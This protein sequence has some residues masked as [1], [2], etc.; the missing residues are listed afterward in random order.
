MVYT[1]NIRMKY[2]AILLLVLLSPVY[3]LDK[4]EE[5]ANIEVRCYSTNILF[6]E[7]LKI[8]KEVPI[9]LGKI[10]DKA[11]STISV[12]ISSTKNWT[13]VATSN[14][15]SCLIGAGTNFEFSP[16]LTKKK[17]PFN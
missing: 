6:D 7:L 10:N 2:L 9:I 12:W 8:H 13:I 4:P 17:D 5:I 3:A 15:I 16:L 11:G 1:L 14:A